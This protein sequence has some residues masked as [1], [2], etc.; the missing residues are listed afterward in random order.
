MSGVAVA[1]HGLTKSFGGTTVLQP[2]DLAVEGGEFVV[3]VGPSGCGKS[4]LLRLLAG[5]EPPTAGRVSIGGRDV[6]ELEPAGRGVAMVF[7]S[8]ALYPHMTVSE[9]IAF[10]LRMARRPKAEIAAK[11]AEVARLLELEPLLA[12]RPR[13]LSGGQRQRVS[14]GRA[15]VRDPAVLLLDEPLSNLDAGL[16]V[17]MR[18]E[19]ARLHQRL[20]ATM[21]YVTH[22]QIE[23]MTLAN[24]IVVMAHGRVEQVGAPLDL[25]RAPVSIRVAEA[26]GSPAMNFVPVTIMR[27]DAAGVEVTLPNGYG[28]KVTARVP[29]ADVGA[30]ATLGVR[31]EHLVADAAGAFSGRVELFERLG[32][33]SFAHLG[34]AGALGSIVAQLPSD[35]HV[36]LGEAVAFSVEPGD[37]HLFAPGGVAYPRL[38]P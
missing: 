22:D 13:A 14:I 9:N 31:P 15:I 12:R 5:L 27:A 24:R 32:P 1:V 25:Y 18:H 10:P 38:N 2:T 23:A 29:V 26:I 4:T 16:R 7:Q 34:E 20:G 8:Y 11:V 3:I 36:T 33:L 37:A 17:R 19:L 21:I 35:R 28:C 6:T 30:S